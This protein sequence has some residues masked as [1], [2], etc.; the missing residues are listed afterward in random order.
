MTL[1]ERILEYYEHEDFRN[2]YAEHLL[3]DRSRAIERIK[4]FCRDK[5]GD[6]SEYYGIHIW[7][8]DEQAEEILDY[9]IDNADEFTDTYRSY[10]ASS[11]CI[12]SVSYG[13]QCEQLTEIYNPQTGKS[14]S[15]PYLKKAFEEAGYM[16]D[17][18]YAY[19]DLSGEGVYIDLLKADIPLLKRIVESYKP[20]KY[21]KSTYEGELIEFVINHEGTVK[22]YTKNKTGIYSTTLEDQ[23]TADY[24]LCD[25][26]DQGHSIKVSKY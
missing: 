16:V 3:E 12:D 18:K 14:Y 25:I 8:T 22:V 20:K 23:H 17:G 1:A 4:E 6:V 5:Y 21:D 13:E 2:N 15:L 26:Q 11:T 19:M 7:L 10:Y 24:L 9:I